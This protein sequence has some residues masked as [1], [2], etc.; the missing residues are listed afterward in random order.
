MGGYCL[1]H[2]LIRFVQPLHCTLG[3]GQSWTFTVQPLGS[4]NPGI[5]SA[6][7]SS[8]DWALDT[9]KT[10]QLFESVKVA[11]SLTEAD[12][13][14]LWFDLRAWGLQRLATNIT[15]P[16]RPWPTPRRARWTRCTGPGRRTRA[17]CARLEEGVKAYRCL[18]KEQILLHKPMPSPAVL[19]QKLLSSPWF[20]ALE[21]NIPTCIIFRRSRFFHRHRYGRR[22]FAKMKAPSGILS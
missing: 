7:Q 17:P 6:G 2:I 12:L 4:L 16:P 14:W 10:V 13:I 5:I 22:E 11:A 3:S 1:L 9:I 19:W 8:P 18:C 20:S 21:A 15:S